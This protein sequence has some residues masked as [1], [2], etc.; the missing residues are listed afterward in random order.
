MVSTPI[1]TPKGK[2]NPIENINNIESAKK[3]PS[4]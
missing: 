2:S 1:K 3:M 4:K